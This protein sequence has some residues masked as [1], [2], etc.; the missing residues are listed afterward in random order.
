MM[1]T[2]K[3]LFVWLCSCVPALVCAQIYATVTDATTRA[4]LPFV[5]VYL[6]ND[7][8]VGLLADDG[9]GFTT[10]CPA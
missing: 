4:P 10:S 7:H 2:T 5:G 8:S 6:Q 3:H 1:M 9:G